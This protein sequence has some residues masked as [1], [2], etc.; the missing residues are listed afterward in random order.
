MS[1]GEESVKFVCVS[2]KWFIGLWT[3]GVVFS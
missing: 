1:S 2:I 3:Y